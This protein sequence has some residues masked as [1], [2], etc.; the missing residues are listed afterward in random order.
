MR[1]LLAVSTGFVLLASVTAACDSGPGAAKEPPALT[2]TAPTRG[3]VQQKANA[4]TVT[5]TVAPNSHGDAVKTV[6]VNGTAA[7]VNTDGSFSAQVTMVDGISLIE[8]VATDDNGG[9]ATDTRAV[10]SGELHPVGDM[11]PAAVTAALSTDSFA[12]ISAAAG[13]L[14]MGLDLGKMIA[15]LQPMIDIGGSFASGKAYVDT[16]KLGGVSVA[17]TPV[18]DGLQFRAE[19]DQVKVAGHV[20]FTLVGSSDSE[21]IGITADKLVI[22]G[23]LKVT[24]NGMNGFTTKLSNPD[25]SVD[26][27]D[28]QSSLL[29]KAITDLLP[30]D[31][32][33]NLVAPPIA[34]LAMGPLMNSALGALAGPQTLNV[35]GMQL[36]VQVNPSAV[37]FASTGGLITL[38][39][40][41][42]IAGAESSPG[43]IYTKN[44]APS[45]DASKGFALALADD[46]ANEMLAELSATG[47]LELAVAVPGGL[48]DTTKVHMTMPPMINADATD[49]KLR[50]L[51]GDMKVTFMN[52]AT[53]V[54][55]AAINAR[56]DL[57]VKPAA[58]GNSVA[59]Q[60]GKPEIHV[61]VLDDVANQT[62][63]DDQ[64][65]ENAAGAVLA[66]QIDSISQLL[67][68]VPLPSLAGLSF[69]NL[70][71]GSDSGYV[72][73][74]GQLD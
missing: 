52:G 20:T 57:A 25:V 68:A 3:L 42:M 44:G 59:L 14:M 6:T 72:M 12:K 35:L 62:G 55:S 43:F 61:D 63:L 7:T 71:V 15:P 60:L 24:P 37:A 53:P 2:I 1:N 31:T 51:L 69:S 56:V 28:V 26:N 16:I 23:I 32:L 54:G 30:L 34:E 10:Q 29:P 36:N 67:V 21:T 4:M 18:E 64:Q 66:G 49:G 9:K 47:K 27:L 41:M 74:K 73:I 19:L 39:M 17:L 70:S 58:N 8:T 46:L 38:D 48:F 22:A 65:L 13:P 11:I 45:L 33:L 50:L 5:G 40:K